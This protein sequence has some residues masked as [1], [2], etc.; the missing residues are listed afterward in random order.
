[1][2]KKSVRLLTSVV[3]LGV[4]GAGYAGVRY[5]V[6]T[7][8]KKESEAEE[9]EA[10]D[11]SIFSAPAE[12]LESV[13]FFVDEKEVT[14]DYDKEGDLWTRRDEAAFPV[15]EDKLSEAAGAVSSLNAERVLEDVENLARIWTG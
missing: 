12:N 3:A 15:N 11:I 1:M 9:K 6:K 13:K 2:K 14:F 10:E 8:E 4:L 7:E 5:Y